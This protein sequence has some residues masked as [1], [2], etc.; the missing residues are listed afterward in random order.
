MELSEPSNIYL[1]S[2]TEISISFAL[3]FPLRYFLLQWTN[4]LFPIMI[5]SLV[6]KNI[7]FT[8]MLLNT[9]FFPCSSIAQ[10]TYSLLFRC[11]YDEMS[12]SV[13][14]NSQHEFVAVGFDNTKPYYDLSGRRGKIW[15][16][17]SP[18]DTLTK[19]YYL[20]DTSLS[21][22]QIFQ[23]GEGNYHVFGIYS[24]PPD[25]KEYSIAMLEL[26]SD[27]ELVKQKSV[28]L[29]DLNHHVSDVIRF[30][31]GNY[32]LF[33]VGYWGDTVK[34]FVFKVDQELNLVNYSCLSSPAQESG[35]YMDCIL[36]PDSTKFYA[37][38]SFPNE[39]DGACHL[40]VYDTALN[41]ISV[42]VFPKYMDLNQGIYENFSHN[43][44]IA[45]F[46]N[47][48][49]LTA[50]VMGK[51]LNWDQE[52]KI[53]FSFL[54][55]TMQWVPPQYF[56]SDDTTFYTAYGRPTFAF[57]NPDSIFFTGTKRQIASFFPQK[58]NWLIAGALDS[59]LQ[60]YFINYYGGD[61]YYHANSMLLTS[62]GG[63][64]ILADRYDKNTQDNEYDVFFLKLDKDG[65][66]TGSEHQTL[67]PQN[68]C[69]IHPNPFND[70]LQIDLFIEK[71]RLSIIDVSGREAAI[72]S[73][74]KGNNKINTISF[75]CG[76]YFARI[77]SN[78]QQ[79]LQ[80]EKLIKIK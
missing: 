3:R 74:S 6:K 35:Y 79:I 55:T 48:R 14:E 45:N 21:F 72:I 59:T 1:L 12:M 41:L 73:L 31:H 47:N 17:S 80:T 19:T 25:Y 16:F 77:I 27:F 62:D 10:G 18:T 46:S 65:L 68:V 44:T 63:Y 58:P 67:C 22:I 28:V 23:N 75:P 36:S 53:G 38:T 60:P 76:I 11:P 42:K 49:I 70:N 51:M 40:F 24:F 20:N 78:K 50:A 54:D 8:A 34:S 69:A 64:L 29:P 7:F 9:V 39:G 26:N 33:G 2:Y 30:F 56:G 61:A 5:H 13:I 32:Y 15:K 43:V 71:A 52:V 57:R 66:I 4:L 37:I